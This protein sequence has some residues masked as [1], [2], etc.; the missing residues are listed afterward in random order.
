MRPYPLLLLVICAGLVGCPTVRDDDD[1]AGETGP[2]I[3]H[4]P[5][6]T[7]TEGTDVPIAAVITPPADAE[8]DL[9][10]TATLAWRADGGSWETVPMEAAGD[11]YS[12]TIPAASV[13]IGGVD[14]YLQATFGSEVGSH[15]SEGAEAPHQITVEAGALADPSPVRARYDASAG[16]V[17]VSWTTSA[18]SAFAG[19]SVTA[20]LDGEDP[21]SVCEGVEADD[22]CTVD[23]EGV[24][25]TDYATWTVTVEDDAGDTLSGEAITDS[26]HLLLDVYARETTPED[27][28]PFGTGQGEFFLPF[29]VAV[30]GGVVHVAEQSNNRLQSFTEDGVFLGFVGALGGTTG[31]P[32]D[33]MGEFSAPHDIAVGPDGNLFV[34]DHTNARVSVLD[35]AT[36][37]AL[38]SWGQLGEGEGDLR[39]PVSVSF[40]GEGLLHVAESVNGRVSVFDAEGVFIETYA[41]AE[42]PFD[43][44]T[45]VEYLPELGVMAIS[46]LGVVHLYPVDDGAEAATWDLD[47]GGTARSVTARRSS[48]WTIRTARSGATATA[49]SGSPRTA[50]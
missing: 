5:V 15:P 8:E 6:S 32:G 47:P 43:T 21:V 28:S 38:F 36:R 12:A 19:Y 45:R 34:A 37:Q 40:D 49:S 17:S 1:S 48:P 35:G 27:P 26:L 13:L 30:H 10:I 39:F 33:G 42:E 31:V 41:A 22:S 14:Y 2:D 4:S 23:A 46:D 16:E 50:R 9:P 29:G 11:D 25:D 3:E 18:S 20:E 24:W 44:P 7:A